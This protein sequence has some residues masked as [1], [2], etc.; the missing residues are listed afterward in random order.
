MQWV[1]GDV[2]VLGE[3]LADIA[4]MIEREEWAAAKAAAGTLLR[5]AEDV[6]RKAQAM[7][8][9]EDRR[10]YV[11]QG[12]IDVME[13]MGFIIQAGYPAPEYPDFSSS[14]TIIQAAR[15][16]GGD[17]ALSVPQQGEVWYEVNGFPMQVEEGST[18][19]EVY[20]CDQAENEIEKIHNLLEAS[21]GIQM[22]ELRWE[23]KDPQ[24]IRKRA[25]DL[26]GCCGADCRRV[27]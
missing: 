19:Q 12:I 14:A 9:A 26:P 1:W 8:L 27:R 16:G 4:A 24:R 17:I 10:Q 20:S 2:E 25:H 11:I 13:E 5:E 18:G 23:G 6:V 15:L 22:G 7:Q 3:K 21:Y